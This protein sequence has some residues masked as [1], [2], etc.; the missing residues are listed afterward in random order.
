MK[1]NG[2]KFF[3]FILTSILFLGSVIF[4]QAQTCSNQDEC[5][6]LIQQYT[7]QIS[8]LQGQANTLKNQIAQF[9]AQ[10]KLT[11]LKIAQTQDKIALLGGRIDQ[12]G[13]SLASLN[14]AF[15]SRAVETYKLSRFENNF[16]LILS[17][18]DMTDAVSRL[19]YL[20]KIQEEDRNLLEKLQT[21]QTTYQGEKTDQEALQKQL[22]AQQANLNAQK[23][24]K[25]NLLT[26]TKNDESKYQQLLSQAKSQLAKFKSF[27]SSR[28]GS[29]ILEN[30]TKCNE[31]WSGCYYNQRDSLWGNL[32]L[33]NSGYLMKDSGCFATSVAMLSSHAGRNIKPNDIANSPDAITPGGDVLHSFNINGIGVSITRIND[34][35]LSRLDSELTAGRPVMAELNYGMHFIVIIRKDGDKYIMNDPFL[36]SG[37][38]KTLTD[39]GYTNS[40]ITGLRL[41]SFN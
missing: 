19:H 27:V 10:I 8:K 37:Y 28:G 22:K 25:N 30:Q 13:D 32:Q 5:N 15:S 26:A 34:N 31:G 29:S 21:A 7:D 12:L 6:N 40:S 14:T 1:I 35:P 33:G 11:T 3:L 38:N 23:T 4:V 9:D 41:V 17:A 39:G 2:K 36:P 16:A 20:Q 18:A 24:A